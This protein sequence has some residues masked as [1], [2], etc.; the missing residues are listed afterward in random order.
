VQLSK[1]EPP[2]ERSSFFTCWDTLGSHRN[3]AG[4][5]WHDVTSSSKFILGLK[6]RGNKAWNEEL[7]FMQRGLN[8]KRST[9]VFYKTY[10]I[11]WLGKPAPAIKIREITGSSIRLHWCGKKVWRR[12]TESKMHWPRWIYVKQLWVRRK[13][14]NILYV[15]YRSVF[16][17]TRKTLLRKTLRLRMVFFPYITYSTCIQCNWLCT[18]L[19]KIG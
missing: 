6:T 11:I 4:E 2:R 19:Y 7:R 12:Q 1:H 15:F 18:F 16:A 3:Q 9:I 17:Q 13:E 8:T 5:P 14:G 10:S